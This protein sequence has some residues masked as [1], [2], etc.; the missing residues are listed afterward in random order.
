M[1]FH[2]PQ[3]SLKVYKFNST[4]KSYKVKNYSIVNIII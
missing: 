1:E 3:A 2:T 4:K